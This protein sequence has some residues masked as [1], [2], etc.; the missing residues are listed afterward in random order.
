MPVAPT[1]PVATPARAPDASAVVKAAP[2]ETAVTAA[3]L[4]PA[5]GQ[6][7]MKV[8]IPK[9]EVGFSS[10][11]RLAHNSYKIFNSLESIVASMVGSSL[12]HMRL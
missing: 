5:V 1:V 2:S 11:N 4:E 6:S 9:A 8:E 3:P 12:P 10:N 7:E